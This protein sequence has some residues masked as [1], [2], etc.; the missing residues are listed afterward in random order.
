MGWWQDNVADHSGILTFAGTVCAA[1]IAGC[2]AI[3]AAAKKLKPQPLQEIQINVGEI[4]HDL[5]E[6]I[7]VLQDRYD[8]CER[9]RRI[10]DR[11]YNRL[12]IKFE[13]ARRKLRALGAPMYDYPTDDSDDDDT[14]EEL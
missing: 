5:R 8:E 9:H 11:K 2:C 6:R 1:V 14:A 4:L 13:W 7:D 12:E 3:V 10:C